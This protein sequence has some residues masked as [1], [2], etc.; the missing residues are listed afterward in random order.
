MF[1][2]ILA[3]VLVTVGLV[4]AIALVLPLKRSGKGYRV[5]PIG[6]ETKPQ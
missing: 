1:Y 3:P 4:G 2:M 5:S 6:P